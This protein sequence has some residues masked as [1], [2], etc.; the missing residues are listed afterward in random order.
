MRNA[1]TTRAVAALFSS[2]LIWGFSFLAIK[3][4]IA[5]VPV[6]SLLFLRFTL[7]ALLLGGLA[8]ARGLLRLPKRDLAVL[9]GLSLLSP[10][11]YFLFETYGVA[12]TQ[13]SHVSIL[14]ATIPIVVYLIALIRR[15]ERW[16]A[17]K[18]LGIALAYGG[19]L[20]IVG[21]SQSEAGAS[22]FGDL[23]VLGAVF[24]A[25]L[26]TS[27]VKDVLRRVRPI[28]LTFYQ[29]LFSLVVFAPLAA[30]DGTAWAADVTAV[31]I[32]EILFLGV[33]CSAIAFLA[34]HY[35]L[36]HL[37][38]TQVAVSA[39]IVPVITLLA[40]ISILGVRLT[41][42]KAVGTAITIAGV[43]FIQLQGVARGGPGEEA[44][45]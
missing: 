45:R 10:V 5:V 44:V 15:Q 7:A 37:S 13:P 25:A 39:N 26:R 40:E 32:L 6:S 24:C 11:G 17:R 22:L 38:V 33:F 8:G 27:L 30:A 29:F 35:A 36:V 43:A 12:Y 3:D 4:V 34:M 23:L 42:A 1:T 19:I 14:I 31:H 2:M 20:L 18:A 21:S 28:Q 16:G 41:L 9:A